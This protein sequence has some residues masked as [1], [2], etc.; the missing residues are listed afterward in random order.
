MQNLQGLVRLPG[1]SKMRLAGK[2][3]PAALGRTNENIENESKGDT[4]KVMLVERRQVSGQLISSK[5]PM[6]A[7][8][9]DRELEVEEGKIVC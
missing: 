9:R 7:V 3:Q 4:W 5:L 8:K 2:I 6:G 1:K